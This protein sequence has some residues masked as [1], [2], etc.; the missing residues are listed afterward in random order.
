M[1]YPALLT[2]LFAFVVLLP[3]NADSAELNADI[4][5]RID[6]ADRALEWVNKAIAKGET[7]LVKQ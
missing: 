1:R 4:I 2:L 6:S 3:V 7:G 5:R